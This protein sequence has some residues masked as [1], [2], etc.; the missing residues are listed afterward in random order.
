MDNPFFPHLLVEER[1]GVRVVTLN[2]PENFNAVDMELHGALAGIWRHLAG[3]PTARA[4]VLTGSGSAFSAGG[5]MA[6]LQRLR[7]DI[8]ERRSMIDEARQIVREML[9]FPLPVV[10]AVNGPAVGLGCSLALLCDI[11]YISNSA[12]LADPHVA[13]GLT[14]G[15]G[16]AATWPLLTSILRAKEYLFTGERI[17]AATALALG[18]AN[19]CVDPEQLM[20]E[21]LA[22]GE[23]LAALPPQA[24]QTTKRALNI[25]LQRAAEG[26]LEY[27]LAAEHDSFNTP[28]HRAIVDGFLAR[29]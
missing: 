19:K 17:P 22:L 12:Y 24:V 6:M 9:A 26:V 14:A 29:N 18:L 21:A 13:V 25:H 8:A 20:T 16:G 4:V 28:E 2:R 15:D 1:D 3:D 11:V 7:D 5:D 23:R 10:A 27:A